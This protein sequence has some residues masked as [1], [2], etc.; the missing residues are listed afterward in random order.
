MVMNKIDTPV[1]VPKYRTRAKRIK[2]ARIHRHEAR[3]R[4]WHKEHHEV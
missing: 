2:E 1:S 3:V 4:A